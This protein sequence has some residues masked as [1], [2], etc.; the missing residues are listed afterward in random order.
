MLKQPKALTM[1]MF[2]N[3]YQIK[4]RKFKKKIEIDKKSSIVFFM[5]RINTN[6]GGAGAIAGAGGAIF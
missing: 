1:L 6:N 5:K 3:I 4:R 2:I